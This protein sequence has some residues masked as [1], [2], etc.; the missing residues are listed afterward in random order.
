MSLHDIYDKSSLPPTEYQMRYSRSSGMPANGSINVNNS[1][2]TKAKLYASTVRSVQTQ[3]RHQLKLKQNFKGYFRTPA[4][5][6]QNFGGRSAKLKHRGTQCVV[7]LWS[8]LPNQE[9]NPAHLGRASRGG[10]EVANLQQATSYC[11]CV[12]VCV[13]GCDTFDNMTTYPNL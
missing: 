7:L 5:A 11:V 9:M 13:R 2:R 12:C 10:V 4:K 1:Y 8:I 3:T 6:V